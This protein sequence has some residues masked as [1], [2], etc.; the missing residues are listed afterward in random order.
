[1]TSLCKY[2][3]L[4]INNMLRIHSRLKI[5]RNKIQFNFFSIFK[6]LQLFL[7]QFPWL[8]DLHR[9]LD[10]FVMIH[11]DHDLPICFEKKVVVKQRKRK[12]T[13]TGSLRSVSER[14]CKIQINSGSS[15]IFSSIFAFSEALC[16]EASKVQ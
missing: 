5:R 2:Q 16:D 7:F 13:C 8:L 15:F 4:Q 10:F 14:A 3:I 11:D 1:M 12:L 6:L 9:R